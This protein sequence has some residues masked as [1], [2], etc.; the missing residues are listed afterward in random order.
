MLF[1]A[2]IFNIVMPFCLLQGFSPVCLS[3]HNL[4]FFPAAKPTIAPTPSLKPTVVPTQVPVPTPVPVVTSKP[5]PTVIPTQAP[6]PSS[7]LFLDQINNYRHSQGLTAVQSDSNTCNFAK[8]RAQEIANNFNHDGFNNRIS[9]KTLPY[10]SYT[11]VIENI[12]MTSNSG[13]VVNMWI[14]SPGH[15]ANMRADTPY[16]CVQSSGNF[17]AYGGW[18]P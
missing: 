7:S 2:L 10:P 8:I 5:S 6:Q 15:A 3:W 1:S 17:Y 18:K 13:D 16:A 11:K 4:T 12:A 9:S 14:N